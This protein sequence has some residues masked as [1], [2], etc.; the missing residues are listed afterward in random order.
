M[1]LIELQEETPHRWR[2]SYSDGNGAQVTSNSLFPSAL[3]AM[4]AA[5]AAYP[6]VQVSGPMKPREPEPQPDRT[7]RLLLIALG[8]VV[9]AI[10]A[11]LGLELRERREGSP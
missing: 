10:L 6:D 9:L 5:R 4:L 1:E 2:W 11:V 8:A 3:E 7:K